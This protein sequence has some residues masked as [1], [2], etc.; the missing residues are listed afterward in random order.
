MEKPEEQL[1][2]IGEVAR[3][4]S[5]S[6]ATIYRRISNGSCPEPIR[7]GGSVRWERSKIREFYGLT[8]SEEIGDKIT[9]KPKRENI[10]LKPGKFKL[11]RRKRKPFLSSCSDENGK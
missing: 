7:T 11:K 10:K 6:I 3:W 4:M 8:K 1:L 5:C 2:T 9:T